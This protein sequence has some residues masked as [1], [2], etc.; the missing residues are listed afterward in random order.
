MISKPGKLPLVTPPGK[1]HVCGYTK[2]P[3]A[4]AGSGEPTTRAHCGLLFSLLCARAASCHGVWRV[5]R[6]DA[7]KEAPSPRRQ[8]RVAC[9]GIGINEVEDLLVWPGL[10]RVTKQL[11]KFM[12]TPRAAAP[13]QPSQRRRLTSHPTPTTARARRGHRGGAG[14]T[15]L[16]P[17]GRS[18]ASSGRSRPN[19]HRQGAR[20]V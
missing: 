14:A 20:A 8:R 9:A 10:A 13:L 5:E 6:L 15:G 3:T 19:R 16:C 1:A 18:R 7:Q 11:P 4:C 17:R 12:R 2:T